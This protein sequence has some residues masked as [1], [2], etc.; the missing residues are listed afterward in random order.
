MSAEE[1]VEFIRWRNERDIVREGKHGSKKV[2]EKGKEKKP[3]VDQV[4]EKAL[5]HLRAKVRKAGRDVPLHQQGR[6]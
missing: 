2:E 1:R 6:A 5:D 4:L 3:F